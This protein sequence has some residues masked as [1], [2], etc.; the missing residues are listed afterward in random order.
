[1]NCINIV[2]R[3]TKEPAPRKTQNGSTLLQMCLAV[4]RGDK[5]RSVDFIDCIAW[6]SRAEFITKYFHKGSPIAVT[7]SLQTRTFDKDDGTKQKIVEVYVDAAN[8]VPR[9]RNEEQSEYD[10]RA[11][12]DID[13]LPRS[14]RINF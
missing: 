12:Q 10:P 1:M 8:F 13:D 7:G 9:E 2:G 3:L 11:E 6:G 4:D 14:E 5:S